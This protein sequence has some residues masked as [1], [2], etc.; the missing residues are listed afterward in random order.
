TPRPPGATCRPSSARPTGKRSRSC[1]TSSW[2]ATTSS[3]SMA[4]SEYVRPASAR[5]GSLVRSLLVEA[6]L[7]LLLL[8]L[9]L[10]PRLLEGRPGR[11]GGAHGR[12]PPLAG[13]RQGRG[14]RPM[15][16]RV[17]GR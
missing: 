7:L 17:G 9:A 14:R 3:R 5:G 12:G 8:V 15:R 6:F 11:R 13:D 1:P 4:T 10:A 2:P 16:A